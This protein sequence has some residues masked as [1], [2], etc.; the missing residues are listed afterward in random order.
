MAALT[1]TICISAL[2]QAP[3]ILTKRS[4]RC[5]DVHFGRTEAHPGCTFMGLFGHVFAKGWGY[6][7]FNFHHFWLL[8]WNVNAKVSYLLPC[9]K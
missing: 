7:H 5:A 2:S 1:I 8:F 4:K 3:I 6:F 9:L